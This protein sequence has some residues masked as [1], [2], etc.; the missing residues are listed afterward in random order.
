MGDNIFAMP[1]HPRQIMGGVDKYDIRQLLP[2][3]SVVNGAR[4]GVN[5]AAV[6]MTQFRFD[7]NIMHWV[8][9]MSYFV[10]RGHFLDGS[11]N[12]LARPPVGTIAAVD[13][14]CSTLFSQIQLNCNGSSIELLQNPPQAD[15]ALA[16]SSVDH[17]W[18]RSSG[19]VSGIGDG[20]QTRMLN[21]AQF[22]TSAV[23]SSNYNELVAAWRPSISL[24]DSATPLPPGAEWRFDFTWSPTAEQNM[25]ESTASK[26]AGTD[27]TFTIDE[28]T[29]YKAAV[30]PSPE[31]PLPMHGII[32]L[33]PVQVNTFQLTG[34]NQLQVNCPL[35]STC[36][37]ILVV[38]QDNN[39]TNNLAAGQNGLKPI[40]SF[41]ASVSNGST[42]NNSYIS[43]FY[44]NFPDLGIQAP[45][46]TYTPTSG[47]V[48]GSKSG[49]ERI[50]QDW[51]QETRGD[52]GGY[53]GSVPM[54]SWDTGIGAQINTPLQTSTPVVQSGDPNNNQQLAYWSTG[55][56]AIATTAY[57]QTAKWGFLGRCPGPIIAV[58]CARPPGKRVSNVNVNMQLSATATSAN[59]Y[60]ISMY[61]KVLAC[62]M[63]QGGKYTY[64]LMD[65]I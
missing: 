28:F 40:T 30:M 65:G 24:F 55:T 35:P 45:N 11:G 48:G 20:L 63:G 33:N 16:Y 31:T 51:I 9:A 6:G 61:S 4:P 10:I 22:G 39:T 13:N 25:I 32:E 38:L 41:T 62:E 19:S 56:G 23:G 14:W 53:E 52:S 21:A 5:G 1:E 57:S 50:Y 47:A 58:G 15:T 3:T 60:V 34:T 8:P 49:W 18:L 12:A 29:F 46:P 42:D 2:A 54:G 36:N 37:R 44:V 64:Q 7:E 17:T 59:V 43:Q 26:I 27:Y